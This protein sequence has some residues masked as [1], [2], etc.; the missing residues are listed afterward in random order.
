MTKVAVSTS[1]LLWAVDRARLSLDDLKSKF[2]RITQW[3]KGEDQPTFRQLEELA[4][5]TSTPFG[6]FFL[7]EPPEERLPVPHFRTQ[8]SKVPERPSAELLDSIQM[9]Q[10]RQ[11]WMREFLVDEGHEALRF[12]KSAHVGEDHGAIVASI[13]SLLGF[14]E[15]WAAHHRTWSE[16][17]LALRDAM[18]HVGILVVVNGIVGNNTHRKLVP[19][20]FRGFVLVDDY[21]PLVFVN[22][23]DAKA[24]QMF[25]LAHELAHILFG[26][27]AAFDL[28]QLLPANDTTELACN[29]VA[30]EFLVP[31]RHLRK[32]WPTV[33]ERQDRF[34][35]LARQ[36]K[37]SQLVAARRALDLALITQDDFREFY[38]EYLANVRR[39]GEQR[40]EGGNFYANL[41]SRIGLR[42]AYAVVRA[43]REGKLLYSEAYRLTGLHAKTFE[44]YAASLGPGGSPQ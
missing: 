17:L 35:E 16:A 44:T 1:V 15:D 22:G 43:V 10:R 2:P 34:E 12:V 6:F 14:D 20:E 36:F 7:P 3:A 42:F 23:A 30:A 28:R 33:Q 8:Q 38:R 24:A 13:R 27:S 41:N 4:R 21:A 18:D 9:M 31:E 26:S 19:G 11:A 40:P 5:S 32:T 39:A 37:I 25:T 29:A